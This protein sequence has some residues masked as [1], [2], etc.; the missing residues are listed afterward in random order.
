MSSS[1]K[2]MHQPE[3]KF[4]PCQSSAEH[5]WKVLSSYNLD[6]EKALDKNSNTQLKY[7]SEFKSVDLLR[8]I[9]KNHPLWNRM[10]KHLSEG[11]SYPLDH[12]EAEKEK[13]DAV[14]ALAFGNHKGVKENKKLFQKIMDEEINN[15]PK[16]RSAETR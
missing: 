11:C 15:N 10:E 3:F 9:F 5:N 8:L 6:L 2:E 1:V 13:E 12:L 7:G 14:E 4:T 16:Q